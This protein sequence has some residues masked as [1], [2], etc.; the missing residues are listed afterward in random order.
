[1]TDMQDNFPTPER[2]KS[3]NEQSDLSELNT[4]KQRINERLVNDWSE[5]KPVT[6]DS[7]LLK[8]KP[9]VIE[10]LKAYLL[11]KG[12]TMTFTSDQRDGSFYSIDA[13]TSQAN[14]RLGYD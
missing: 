2:L 12:W 3:A 1:M 10:K 8:A 13:T 5:G 6:I 9:R 4:L 11:S 14:T 7:S